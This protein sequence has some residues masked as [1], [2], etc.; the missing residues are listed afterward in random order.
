MSLKTKLINKSDDFIKIKECLIAEYGR[1]ERI[2]NDVV[3]GLLRKKKPSSGSRKEKLIYYS[4]ILCA[5]Q[6][7]EKLHKGRLNEC[8]VLRGTLSTLTETSKISQDY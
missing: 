6:R 1:P 7:V 5:I 2:I 4:D 3:A 8:L